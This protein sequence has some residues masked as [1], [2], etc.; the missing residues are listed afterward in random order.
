[1]TTNS[2]EARKG[3]PPTRRVGTLQR[4]GSAGQSK[5]APEAPTIGDGDADKSA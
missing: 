3:P 5:S 2:D 4:E 1:L